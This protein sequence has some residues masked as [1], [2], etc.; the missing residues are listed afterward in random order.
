MDNNDIELADFDPALYE[1]FQA[2]QL[3][4]GCDDE[5][6]L[7]AY[8]KGE[9]DEEGAFFFFEGSFDDIVEFSE[10]EQILISYIKHHQDQSPGTTS[11]WC[12]GVIAV[13]NRYVHCYQ[14]NPES[15][16]PFQVL[17]MRSPNNLMVVAF[18]A[19][20]ADSTVSLEYRTGY[21]QLAVYKDEDVTHLN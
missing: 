2:M 5:H 11:W 21:T 10:K 3:F 12:R 18:P 9:G 1:L 15:S 17:D 16:A 6:V 19:E 4:F 8:D 20:D 7:L 13:T 14:V